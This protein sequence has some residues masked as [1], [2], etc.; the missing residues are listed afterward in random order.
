MTFRKHMVAVVTL[1]LAVLAL[2]AP[3][4]RGATHTNLIYNVSISFNVTQ[5]DFVPISTNQFFFVTRKSTFGT[6]N[7]ADTLANTPLFKTNH[8]QG[9][10]LL[11][12]VTDLGPDRDAA[13]ILRKGT[14]DFDIRDYMTLTF[15][16]VSVNSKVPG[17]N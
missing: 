14:K 12:R 11:F 15:P 5:Q 16:G 10:K 4:S 6:Q 1:T 3:S 7:I 8:L 13:F 17:S 9:A 2:P